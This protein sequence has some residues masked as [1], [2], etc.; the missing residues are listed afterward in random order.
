VVQS[1]PVDAEAVLL[2]ERR[3]LAGH[4]LDEVCQASRLVRV[5]HEREYVDLEDIVASARS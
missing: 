1:T 4:A 2:L 5:F 3:P